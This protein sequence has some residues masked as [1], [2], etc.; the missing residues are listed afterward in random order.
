MIALHL[1]APNDRNGNP[2][3]LFAVLDDQGRWYDMI[4]EG[5]EGEAALYRRHQKFL[6]RVEISPSEYKRL[7]KISTV[8]G[9]ARADKVR[10]ELEP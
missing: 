9:R 6:A 2:R 10:A 1:A 3:R 5:Y 7:R 8:V 4:E